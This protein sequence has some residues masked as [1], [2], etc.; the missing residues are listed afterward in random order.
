MVLS[1]E[2]IYLSR[3]KQGQRN[4][5]Y[6]DH[7]A[8]PGGGELAL[9]NLLREINTDKYHPVVALG[10]DGIIRQ[11][12]HTSSIYTEVYLDD[13]RLNRLSRRQAIVHGLCNPLYLASLLKAA[14]SAARIA[15]AEHAHLIHCNSLKADLIGGVAGRIVHLPVLWHIRDCLDPPNIPIIPSHIFRFLCNRLPACITACSDAAL[16]T[17]YKKGSSCLSKPAAVVIHDGVPLDRFLIPRECS[18]R[19]KQRIGIIGRISPWKGQHVF[20][21]ASSKVH[22]RYPE[23]HFSITGSALFGEEDYEKGLHLM[24]QKLGLQDSVV[25]N[26][27]QSNPSDILGSLDIL[28]HASTLPEPFGQVVAEGMAAG[29]AVAASDAGGVKELIE[30]GVNG[31]LTPMGDSSALAGALMEL[32]EN[33]EYASQLGK[34]ARIRILE[35]FSM[36]RTVRRMEELYEMLL[37]G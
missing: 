10:E 19:G 32:I 6:L 12:L 28:V 2:A 13:S 15:R 18:E 9:V 27:F 23:V 5:L 21:E 33:P 1:T 14:L 29:R 11:M 34:A 22:L 16:N 31:E 17:L 7:T 30:N 20:L 35:N 37:D 8:R 25:F 36:V 4:I 24:V 26:G 3:R